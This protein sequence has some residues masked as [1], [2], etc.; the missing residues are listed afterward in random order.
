MALIEFK[1]LPDTTTPINAENLNNNF[2]E[3]TPQTLYTGKLYGS[4]TTTLSGVKKKLIIYARANNLDSV[5]Y[6]IDIDEVS[7]DQRTYGSGM[8]IA[9]DETGGADYYITESSFNSSTGIFKHERTGF[10]NISSGI[11]TSRNKG[12]S[13]S[14]E[15]Y[16]VYRI[17]TI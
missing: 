7:Q 9:F 6:T 15:H 4:D 8:V 10:A 16:Y 5:V 13:G 1:D 17:E 2:T 11:Y 14:Y 12:G 3:C